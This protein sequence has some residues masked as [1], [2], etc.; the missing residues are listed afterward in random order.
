MVGQTIDARLA[1]G[2][3]TGIFFRGSEIDR[4]ASGSNK[5]MAKV[6]VVEKAVHVGAEDAARFTYRAVGN[7]FRRSPMRDSGERESSGFI[8]RFTDVDLVTF[9]SH[10][11]LRV[12]A[13]K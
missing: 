3:D 13:K 9:E 5:R 8:K 6:V 11:R 2:A 12:A 7:G 10:Q 1:F 4:G